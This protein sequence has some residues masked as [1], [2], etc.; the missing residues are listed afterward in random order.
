MSQMREFNS[1]YLA[2]GCLTLALIKIA[3]PCN[4]RG[5]I[6]LLTNSKT[7]AIKFLSKWHLLFLVL[8]AKLAQVSQNLEYWVTFGNISHCIINTSLVSLSNKHRFP[9]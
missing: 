9:K 5:F 1:I 7:K 8:K 6:I 2:V 4:Q 3:S